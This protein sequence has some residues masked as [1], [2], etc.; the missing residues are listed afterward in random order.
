MALATTQVHGWTCPGHTSIAQEGSANLN[1]CVTDNR[2]TFKHYVNNDRDKTITADD[3]SSGDTS[4]GDLY[5]K[6]YDLSKKVYENRKL[7]NLEKEDLIHLLGDLSNPMHNVI[8]KGYNKKHHKEY[9]SIDLGKSCVKA[10]SVDLIQTHQQF[11]ESAVKLAN[12]AK[13][14]GYTDIDN[15]NMNATQADACKLASQSA[16][17]IKAIVMRIGEN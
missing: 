12:D 13:S 2:R 4:N 15:D 10:N 6:I 8:Y 9:D 3:F 16:T 7:N 11:I 1:A 5:N 17:L 14:A